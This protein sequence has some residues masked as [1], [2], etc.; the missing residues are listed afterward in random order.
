MEL[1]LLKQISI[2]N[3]PQI[4]EAWIQEQISK[5]PSILNLGDLELKDKERIQPNA[6]RLD[7]LLQD[8]DTKRRYE[9]E[10]QLGKTDES[11]IIRT[12]EYWDIERKRYPQYDHC[13]VI[14]AEDITSRFLNVIQLFNGFIPIIA[15]QM[16]AYELN[17][18][19]ALIFT[20]IVDELKLG[21]DDE[22]EGISESTDRNYWEIKGSKETVKYAD[23]ILSII[24][25]IDINYSIT[26]K[27]HYIGLS[28]NGQADNFIIFRAKKK[29][30]RMEIKLEK[31]TEVEEFLE[32]SVLDVME[33]NNRSNRYRIKITIEDIKENKEII[34][35]II[36][37]S[38][39][40]WNK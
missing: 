21:L 38:Y 8:F 12:I 34:K 39:D 32:N 23:D 25:E 35:D 24:K 40:N 2:K 37:R 13:A 22:D 11:H 27:K 4:N 20:K 33:Y 36:K 15:L 1:K 9:V 7:L 5:N 3:H 29:Y 6:G 10:I 31:T 16:K 18:G 17:D 28:K 30:L 26:Y 19:V 14:I